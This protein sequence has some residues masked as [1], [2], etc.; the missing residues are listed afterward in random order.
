MISFDQL[1]VGVKIRYMQTDEVY[2]ISRVEAV[3]RLGIDGTPYM[4]VRFKRGNGA[5]RSYFIYAD[6][7]SHWSIVP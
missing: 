4:P 7:L 3:E 6:E 2:A 5:C 1:K